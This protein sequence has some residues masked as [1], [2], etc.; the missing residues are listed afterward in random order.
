MSSAPAPPSIV[1]FPVHVADL[2]PEQAKAYRLADNR[3]N[4]YAE[5]DDGALLQE[6]KELAAMTSADLSRRSERTAFPV[7]DLEEMLGA[8]P[9]RGSLDD[10]GRWDQKKPVECPSC[11]HE[12][13][14]SPASA[15]GLVYA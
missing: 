13:V 7:E 14:P 10:Q 8:P 1:S 4:E 11:G 9:A 15:A 5:W 3:A 2:T 6:L 12:F